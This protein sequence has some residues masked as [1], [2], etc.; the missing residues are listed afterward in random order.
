MVLRAPHWSTYNIYEEGRWGQDDLH[1]M[2]WGEL[3]KEKT[4]SRG[5]LL[6]ST[7]VTELNGR[8]ISEQDVVPLLLSVHM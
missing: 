7:L 5:S 6:Q 1:K 3:I 4:A 8:L 2:T